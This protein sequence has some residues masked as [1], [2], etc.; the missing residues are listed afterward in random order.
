MTTGPPTGGPERRGGRLRWSTVLLVVVFVGAVLGYLRVRPTPIAT[1]YARPATP[2]P[3]VP[4]PAPTHRATASPTP[5]RHTSVTGSTTSTT[6][7]P[8]GP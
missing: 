5:A 3:P 4:P 6:G 2:A 8:G 7:A 1:G